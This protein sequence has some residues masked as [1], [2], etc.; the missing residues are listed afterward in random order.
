MAK[1]IKAGVFGVDVPIKKEKVAGRA[2]SPR[3]RKARKRA[4]YY[5]SEY[6]KNVQAILYLQHFGV[7]TPSFKEPKKITKSSVKAIRKIYE[8]TKRKID[9]IDG[10]FIDITTGEILTKLPTKQ[11]AAK[12]Y[13]E[14]QAGNVVA[15]D[16]YD[17][18]FTELK[19]RIDSITPRRDSDKTEE[20][21]Q[22]N[23]VPIQDKIKTNFKQ[24]IDDAIAKYG[25]ERIANRLAGNQYMQRIA[26]LDEKYTYEIVEDISN[27]DL[28]TLFDAS[29]SD[30][31]TLRTS[32]YE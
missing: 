26:N 10:E 14:E 25:E 28:F 4:S 3:Q 5:K 27:G 21:Y 8:E 24:A 32:Y 16:P 29:V 1:K 18:Y 20:N 17:N 19:E 23:V 12:A 11:E 6:R 2:V 22:R 9:R 15:F 13:R 30:A 31:L 7:S